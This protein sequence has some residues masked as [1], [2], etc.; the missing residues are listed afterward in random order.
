[1]RVM[2]VDPSTA[3]PLGISLVTERLTVEHSGLFALEEVFNLIQEWKPDIIVVEDQY[4]SFNYNTAKK[5]AWC[6]GKIM[7]IALI[8]GVTCEVM[9][10]AHWKKIMNCRPTDKKDKTAHI[11]R[12]TETFKK[13]YED[14]VA[15]AILIATAYLTEN[16]LCGII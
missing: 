2:G 9:N 6:A 13:E 10:V 3:K 5:L 14:D 11:R 15:S 4:L 1:M 8:A 12:C 7:G 16:K